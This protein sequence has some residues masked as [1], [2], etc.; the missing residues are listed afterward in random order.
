MVKLVDVKQA[1]FEEWN[2]VWSGC[3]YATY[4]HSL[5]W[6]EIWSYYTKRT[7]PDAKL[8]TFNDGTSV[9]LPFSK[10]KRFKG[11]LNG[12]VSSPA[13]T[14]GGWISTD[15]IGAQH[16]KLLQNHIKQRYKSL[17]CRINPYDPNVHALDLSGSK[18]DETHAIDLLDG[19]DAIYKQWSKGHSSAARKA[20]KARREGVLIKKATNKDEWAKYYSVYLDSIKRWGDKASSIYEWRLF[21]EIYDR[22][23]NNIKLWIASHHGNI[24]SGSLCFYARKHVVYWHGAALEEYFKLRPVN[25]LMY[26]AIKHACENE[27]RWFDFNPSGGHEGVKA[28]KKSFGAIPLP[29]PIIDQEYSALRVLHLAKNKLLK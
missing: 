16:V 1:T 10:V 25:L 4:F 17:T 20:R 14:F 7:S 3:D 13:G 2:S 18:V 5:E 22:K 11:I 23:S 28:F 21:E 24:I 27:Y 9:I 12:Y 19:F 26:E 6:A 29:S 15:G 8:V